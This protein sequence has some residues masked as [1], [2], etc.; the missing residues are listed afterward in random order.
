MSR[1]YDVSRKGVPV[2]N[3]ER[4][5]PRNGVIGVLNSVRNT[6]SLPHNWDGLDNRESPCYSSL[7]EDTMHE[8]KESRLNHV[9]CVCQASLNGAPLN[10]SLPT[11]HGYCEACLE[12][13]LV[14]VK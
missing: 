5:T 3:F 10:P 13:A 8:T 2:D 1:V 4:S 7:M 9:C 6:L 12:I 14:N 11:S